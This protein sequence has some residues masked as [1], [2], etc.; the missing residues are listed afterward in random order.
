[1]AHY[2]LYCLDG[3][4]KITAAEWIEAADDGEA[5]RIARGM[6]KSVMCEVWDRSRLVARVSA[7]TS[8]DGATGSA[9]AGPAPSQPSP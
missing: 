5:V 4:E 2:R 9:A 1:M 8:P 7:F 3:A 6:K